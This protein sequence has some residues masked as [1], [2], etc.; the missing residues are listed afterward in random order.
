MPCSEYTPRFGKLE[1]FCLLCCVQSCIGSCKPR[2]YPHHSCSPIDS[3]SGCLFA[4]HSLLGCLSTNRSC[5]I[6]YSTFN[7]SDARAQ[8]IPLRRRQYHPPSGSN[9]GGLSLLPKEEIK[10]FVSRTSVWMG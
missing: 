8:P 6:K 2:R 5:S 9:Q 7:L 1:L 3:L 10:T 4:L